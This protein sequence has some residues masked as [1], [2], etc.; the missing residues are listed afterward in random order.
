[1]NEDSECSPDRILLKEWEL[2]QQM[3]N[4]YGNITWQIGSILIAASILTLGFASDM[5]HAG[6]A[7]PLA[8]LSMVTV[9]TWALFALRNRII[10]SRHIH[11][12][13]EIED[14]LRQ[15]FRSLPACK[16]IRDSPR[17]WSREEATRDRRPSGLD[18]ALLLAVSIC[19]ADI[20]LIWMNKCETYADFI[21][22]FFESVCGIILTVSAPIVVSILAFF[23]AIYFFERA[24]EAQFG[25]S[26]RYIPL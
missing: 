25:A 6:F 10:W 7:I 16:Q 2:A 26:E 24:K 11:R 4:Y 12:A 17:I 20:H 13:R 8:Y 23:V 5:N 22:K 18:L 19:V 1:M 14:Y 21:A 15:R 9:V 3:H